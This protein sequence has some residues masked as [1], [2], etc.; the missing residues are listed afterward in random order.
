MEEEKSL[1]KK[2]AKIPY[3]A[4]A[5]GMAGMI[6]G[7]AYFFVYLAK[8]LYTIPRGFDLPWLFVF[9]LVFLALLVKKRVGTARSDN[10]P[11]LS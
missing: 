5:L 11:A 4:I 6:T 9:A 8:F 2:L 1:S 3:P 7:A 10:K